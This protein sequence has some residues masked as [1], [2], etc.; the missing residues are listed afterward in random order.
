MIIISAIIIIINFVVNII[1][2]LGCLSKHNIDGSENVIWK[3][4]FAFLQ[5]FF[6][7][8]AWK[9]CFNYPGIKLEPAL[10]T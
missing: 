3:C 8:Y 7:Y 10:G 2:L 4:H 9:M 6:K 5:S 1:S